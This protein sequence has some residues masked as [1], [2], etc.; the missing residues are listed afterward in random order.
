ME[1]YQLPKGAEPCRT[2]CRAEVD[3][4]YVQ[5]GKV[6]VSQS[7]TMSGATAP[8]L[9]RLAP[10]VCVPQPPSCLDL[11]ITLLSTCVAVISSCSCF[12]WPLE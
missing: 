5:S 9:L 7:T 2:T 3:M 1:D 12:L 6:I 8:L 10:A 11:A 4:R